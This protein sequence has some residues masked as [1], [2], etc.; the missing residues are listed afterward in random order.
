MTVHAII[1]LLLVAAAAFGL[2]ETARLRG[3][4]RVAGLIA[5]LAAPALLY[6]ILFPPMNTL[7]GTPLRVL[8]PGAPAEASATTLRR[9]ALPGAAADAEVE[10]VPDLATAL[11]RYPGTTALQVVGDGLGAADRDAARDLALSFDAGAPPRGI[12]ALDLPADLRAGHAFRLA[13]RVEPAAGLRIAVRE[14]GGPRHEP[15]AADAD[16][17]FAFTLFAPRAADVRYELSVLDAAGTEIEKLVV[18]L[19]IRDGAKLRLL[20]LAGGPDAD[21][22][23]LQRWALDA[24]HEVEARI[25]L[26][27]GL[28]QQRGSAELSAAALAATDV[29]VIDDRAWAQLDEAS[30]TR[31]LDAVDAGLG[32]LLRLGAA[33]GN[34]LATQWRALG[35]DLQRAELDPAVRLSGQN[36]DGATGAPRR[37]PLRVE[38]AALLNLGQDRDGVAF[39]RA[40]N[41]GLGRL[42]VWWLLDSATLTLSGQPALHDALWARALDALARPRQPVL[43][44]PAAPH[45]QYERIALC[46]VDAPLRVV[47][48]SGDRVDVL[49]Q[50]G[51]DARWCGGFWP[52][53]SGWHEWQAGERRTRFFVYAHDDARALHRAATA[54][55]TR[56]LAGNAASAAP[57]PS[58]GARWPWFLAW[59]ATASLLWWLQRARARGAV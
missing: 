9:V 7:P 40:G 49:A 41:R 42:G 23:Y 13:G 45:W 52:R 39:G 29:V 35:F 1:L 47:A 20:L 46:A 48:P 43:P 11:R 14:P 22:K 18:P 32:L 8:T 44:P 16:G 6:L 28:H 5:A 10:R 31:L 34:T 33:P 2:A 19:E 51:S 26:S 36:E 4:R 50:R 27:R 57:T 30:R 25:T 56:L 15:V 59:L 58:P 53:E 17:R 24:G 12:V 3:A 54:A 37:L 21:L 38:G 55:A